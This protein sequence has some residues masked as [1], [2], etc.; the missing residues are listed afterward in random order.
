[1]IRPTI[2]TW[3]LVIFSSIIFIALLVAQ[4]I[5][6]LKPKSQQ[7]KDILI[8][9]G[10]DWRDNTHFKVAYAFAWADWIVIFPLIAAGN[11]SVLF[12]HAWGYLL[13]IILGV[14]S[15]YFS[16]VFYIMEKEYTYPK[17]GFI[18]YYTY[19]WGFYLYWGILSI[20]YSIIKLV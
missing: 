18:G 10:E 6:I 1:M 2:L 8:G 7:A 9:K 12:G 4:L 19:L 20:V 15:I 17:V 3:V 11:I 16:V 14:I 13:W 5:I